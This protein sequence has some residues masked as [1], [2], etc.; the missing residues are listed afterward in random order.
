MNQYH[1]RASRV[2][3]AA[4]IASA[5]VLGCYA[6]STRGTLVLYKGARRSAD[7]VATIVVAAR[8]CTMMTRTGEQIGLRDTLE[9]SPGR[10]TLMLGPSGSQ[11][12]R[13]YY[14]GSTTLHSR[15]QR[16][17]RGTPE[18][19]SASVSYRCWELSFDAQAGHVYDLK[20]DTVASN[21][22]ELVLIDR[23]APLVTIRGLSN[24]TCF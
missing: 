8:P 20:W 5:L 4:A 11:S 22:V 17:S 2:V 12:V 23:T 19:S 6:Q 14:Y 24:Q 21:H 18:V 3:L 9:L 7:S 1:L 16:L 13:R 10:T 15:L